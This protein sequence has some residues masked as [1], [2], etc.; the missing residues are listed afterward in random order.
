MITFPN[1]IK[2]HLDQTRE[3]VFNLIGKRLSDREIIDRAVSNY[4]EDLATSTSVMMTETFWTKIKKPYF[5]IHPPVIKGLANTTLSLKP[6][7]IPRSIVND[8]GI[9]CV[10]FPKEFSH[11]LLRGI[12]HF[13]LGCGDVAISIQDASVRKLDSVA[14]S[15]FNEEAVFTTY[16]PMD[17]D[18]LS[19]NDQKYSFGVK[20]TDFDLAQRNFITRI[21][22]GV[23][24]LAADPAFIEPVLLKRDYGKNGDKDKLADKARRNGVIGF[25]IGSNMEVSPHFRRPHFSIRWTGK[26]SQVPRLVYVKGSVIHKSQLEVPTGYEDDSESE[27]NQP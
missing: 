22:L 14:I 8:L 15:Y 6:R 19:C 21:G 13:Y 26:G 12:T 20:Q 5:N 25:E 11:K 23:L 7:S 4:C 10:K 1:P 3:L 9:V 17:E 16:C 24:L 2:T 18:F 27:T